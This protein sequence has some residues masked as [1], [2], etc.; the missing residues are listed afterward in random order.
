MKGAI[1]GDIIGSPYEWLSNKEYW[2]PPL[3]ERRTYT[4]DTVMT[5]AVAKALMAGHTDD[6]D[7]KAEIVKQTRIYGNKY[8]YAG[9]GGMFSQWLRVREPKPYNSYGNGSAMRVSSV[10]WLY[11]DL[12]TVLH[13]AR[14][15]A[16]VTH[17]HPEGIKGAQAVAACVYLAR[18]GHS[19]RAIKRYITKT[20]D[21]DLTRPVDYIRV[22]YYF[23]ATCQGSVPE[24]ISCFLQ[25]KNF[26]DAIRKAYV[27]E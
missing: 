14:L 11:D 20:F 18:T 10:G 1:I 9:Y 27:G 7:I 5:L 17:N 4:D 19:K 16:E 13:M 26:D 24:A 2:F 25:S 8:P 15:T 6:G 22:N 12:D 21:Y 3:Y 23:D